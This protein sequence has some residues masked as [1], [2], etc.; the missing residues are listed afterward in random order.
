MGHALVVA[1]FE[2]WAHSRQSL[3]VTPAMEAGISD[4]VWSIEE[5]IALFGET[6]D[7]TLSTRW[8]NSSENDSKQGCLALS[9]KTAWRECGR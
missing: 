6:A 4:L 5:M 9:L 1:Q 8:P 2:F 3:C 7:I